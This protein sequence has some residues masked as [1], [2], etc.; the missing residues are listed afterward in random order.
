M[1][2]LVMH[3]YTEDDTGKDANEDRQ[4]PFKSMETT[5]A[6]YFISLTPAGFVE[7]VSKPSFQIKTSFSLFNDLFLPSQY[8]PAIWQPPRFI[9]LV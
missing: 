9:D 4:L 8:L 3:Y 2:F 5:A 6:V 7:M 1:A